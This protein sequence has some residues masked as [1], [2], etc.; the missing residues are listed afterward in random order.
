VDKPAEKAGMQQSG[1]YAPTGEDHPPGATFPAAD[2]ATAFGISVDRVRRAMEGEFALQ[3]HGDVDSKQAQHLAEV[4][5]GD[6]PQAERDAALM[7]LGAFTPRTDHAWGI[8]E[9]PP[10]EESD[11]VAGDDDHISQH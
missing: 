5:L 11:R 8:G 2:V 10:G 7:R 4:L 6:R 3:A 9:A 1:E